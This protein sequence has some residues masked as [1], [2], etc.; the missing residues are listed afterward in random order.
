MRY[1]ADKDGHWIPLEREVSST[2]YVQPDIAEFRSPDGAHI[3]GRA[4]W[5]EHLKR[6]GTVE[7]GHA[8]LKDAQR[9]WKKRKRDFAESIK[10]AHKHGVK[11]AEVPQQHE[12][13]RDYQRSRLN[14]EVRNRLEG[15]PAPSL[16]QLL[17]ITL[18][19]RRRRY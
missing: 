4:Q 19:E 18:E 17:K 9:A 16:T 15:R 6:T 14:A 13:I 12:E 3:T 10:D 1:V 2:H 11:P 5:R 7:M 8:D